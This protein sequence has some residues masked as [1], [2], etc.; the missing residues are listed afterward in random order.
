MATL[1]D[2][3]DII[4][5]GGYLDTPEFEAYRQKVEAVV[6]ESNGARVADIRRSLGDEYIARWTMDAIEATLD[7]A[8][9]GINF[10]LYVWRERPE[11]KRLALGDGNCS[12]YKNMTKQRKSSLPYQDYGRKITA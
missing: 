7:I 12:F 2:E 1:K 3:F 11:I 4:S 10:S 9:I 8:D 6:K 5:T